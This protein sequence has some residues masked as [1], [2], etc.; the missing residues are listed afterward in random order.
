L[1]G[2]QQRSRF[3][4][5][6]ITYRGEE[7]RAAANIEKHGFKHFLPMIRV[8]GPVKELN[9]RRL[10]FP[11]YIFVHIKP[12]WE[13]LLHVRGIYQFILVNCK[14]VPI[15]QQEINYLTELQDEHGLIN[16]L[17]RFQVGQHVKVGLRPGKTHSYMVGRQG[18]VQSFDRS[19]CAV[20][21]NILGRDVRKVFDE[22]LLE[23]A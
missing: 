1:H 21:F 20:L 23:A 2:R 5:A 13:Q 22:R 10:L 11:G 17:S 16:R 3:W 9:Y 19:R 6:A 14:P 15:P 18:T 8:H 7:R 12:N 4:A